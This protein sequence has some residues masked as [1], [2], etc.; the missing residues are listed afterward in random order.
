[1]ALPPRRSFKRRRNWRKSRKVTFKAVRRIAHR[2]ALKTQE[3][4][5]QFVYSG[6]VLKHN[7]VYSATLVNMSQGNTDSTRVGDEIFIKGM[8]FNFLL[9]SVAA[10]AKPSAVRMLVVRTPLTT[11]ADSDLFVGSSGQII[12]RLVNKEKIT[13]LYDRM[14][15][16]KNHASDSNPQSYVHKVHLSINKKHIFSGD[17]ATT[18]K[19]YNYYLIQVPFVAGGTTGTTDAAYVD[20]HFM[21]TYK[22]A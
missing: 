11:L 9:Q 20:Q 16:C 12:N 4:K 13:V 5:Q 7:T 15:Y 22:D 19:Y 6:G 14:Y 3:T 10:T 18:G 2:E 21:T 17:N 1:M 8:T